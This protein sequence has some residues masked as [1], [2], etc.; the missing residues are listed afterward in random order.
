VTNVPEPIQRISKKNAKTRK[1]NDKCPTW[2]LPGA[3]RGK[4]GRKVLSSRKT[5]S[6]DTPGKLTKLEKIAQIEGSHMRAYENRIIMNYST[7]NSRRNFRTRP[8]RSNFWVRKEAH[9][10]QLSGS[11]PNELEQRR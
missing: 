8:S 6:F 10:S 11:N 9:G 4:E 7:I 2:N 1:E 3:G 5:A